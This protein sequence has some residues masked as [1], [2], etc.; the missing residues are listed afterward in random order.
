[1]VNVVTI[2]LLASMLTPF[3]GKEIKSGRIVENISANNRVKRQEPRTPRDKQWYLTDTAV[4]MNVKSAWEDGFTGKEV[5]VAVVDDGVNMNHPNLRLNFNL[6]AS[7]DVLEDR[8][9]SGS[10]SPGS[11]GTKCAG[12]IAGSNNTDCGIGIAFDAQI[13][14][15]RLY[16]DNTKSSDQ[17][18]ARALSY[19]RDLIDVYSNSWGPGD[20]GWQVEGPGPRLTEALENGTRWG[21]HGKGSIFVFAAG[22]GGLAGDN[23]A[24]NGYAN[25]IHTIAI[26]GVNWDG[27]VPDYSEKCSAIMA[28][29]YG[30]NV[31]TYGNVKAPIITAQGNHDCTED[32]PGTSGTTA[33]ASGIIALAL[34]ANPE[35][36]WRDVQHLIVRSSKPLSSPRTSDFSTT[37]RPKPSWKTNAANLS[38]SSHFGFGLMDAYTIVQYS[39]NWNSVPQQLYCEVALDISSSAGPQIPWRGQFQLPLSVSEHNCSIRF[40]EHVQVQFDL[41]FPRR[42]Y[43]RMSS[44]SPSRTQSTLFYPRAFDSLTG[45]KR[46]SN[47]TVTSLHYWGENPIGNWTITIRNTKPR[48]NNRNGHVFFLKLMLYGTKEDPLANNPHVNTTAK[49]VEEVEIAQRKADIVGHAATCRNSA[50]V[51][52]CRRWKAYCREERFQENCAKTCGR[53]QVCKNDGPDWYCKRHAQSCSNNRFFRKDC[54]KTCELC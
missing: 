38:V 42:G 14:S 51:R 31:L 29:T 24:F 4:S 8:K 18:E 22:N 27:R 12:I 46:F 19:K 45:E 17:S 15:L 49:L 28:V 50:S 25:S 1:M 43:L 5:L 39:R 53:C 9:I 3:N 40:L 26:S 41:S 7:Y 48:R 34:E 54:K 23:C 44:V 2:V 10:H 21:R 16:D 36:T 33:M 6:R 30:Q 52:Y 32:F 11:H 37:R 47:W 20:M 35:L 13:A